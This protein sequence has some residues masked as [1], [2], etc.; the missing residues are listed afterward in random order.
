MTAAERIE[1]ARRLCA[2]ER[3]RSGTDAERRAAGEL[4]AVLRA[5]GRHAELEPTYVHRQL[6]LIGALHCALGV[7]GSL[8]A[9]LAPAVGF[10]IVLA[11]AASLYLDANG[12]A[13]LLRRLLFR[14]AS[15]NVVSRGPSPEAPARLILCAH[16]DAGRS[17]VAYRSRLLRRAAR[18]GGTG[19]ARIG[20]LQVVFWSVAALLPLIGARMAGVEE[21]WLSAVQLAPT[22]VLIA[23]TFLF[24]DLELS[25]VSP[26]ADDNASGVATVLSLADELRSDPPAALDVWVVLSGGEEPLQAGMRELVRAHRDELDPASTYV[27]NLDAVGRGEPRYE[28]RSGWTIGFAMGDR[29]AELCEAI[30]DAAGAGDGEPVASPLRRPTAGDSLP[31]RLARIPALTITC[32]APDGS[33]PDLRTGADVVEALDP[34]SLERAHSFALALVRQLDRDVARR[35]AGAERAPAVVE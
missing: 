11:T 16:Y 35:A 24:V 22:L 28:I 2:F 6:G 8:V 15:Q 29:L 27:V 4:A 17:G 12:R 32:R 30:V 14:R 10:A 25:P 13:Y 9:T 31:A 18:L 19:P 23:A 34:D 7:V 1:L 5:G 20:P 26:G 21:T 33:V 3:R